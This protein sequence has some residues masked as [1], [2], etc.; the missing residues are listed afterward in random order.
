V[1]P[2]RRALRA[3]LLP[4]QNALH[5][6][7]EKDGRRRFLLGQIVQLEVSAR[8]YVRRAGNPVE[9]RRACLEA[10]VLDEPDAARFVLDLA[11]GD[12]A[13][14]RRTLF[15]ARQK[16]GGSFTYHHLTPP[17]EPIL[18]VADALAWAWSHGSPWRSLVAPLV[19]GAREV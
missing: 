14:D 11:E 13:A 4:G 7:K 16:C 3:L 1:E 5:F 2:A 6:K 19:A 12:R 15:D 10:A 17:Q 18:W 8:I 9:A